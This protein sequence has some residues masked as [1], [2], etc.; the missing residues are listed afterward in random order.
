MARRRAISG[1]VITLAR[2]AVW[3]VPN[4]AVVDRFADGAFPGRA[5]LARRATQVTRLDT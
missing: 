3:G 2:R 5:G 4:V 1:V